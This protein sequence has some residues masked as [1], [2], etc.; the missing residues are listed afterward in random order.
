MSNYTTK[1]ETLEVDQ[2]TGE[3]LTSITSKTFTIKTNPDKFYMTF[4]DYMAPLFKIRSDI[5]KSI[6]AW[7]CQHAEFNKGIVY[8]PSGTRKKL[9]EE[10]QI[11]SKN[12]SNYLKRLKDLDLIAGQD[13]EYQ[14]NPLIFWKGTINERNKKLSS[15]EIRITFEATFKANQNPQD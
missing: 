3:V 7:L 10:L 15:E 5:S 6:L 8:L 14:I 1:T 11:T 9:C 13:G 2:T 12:L 4:I